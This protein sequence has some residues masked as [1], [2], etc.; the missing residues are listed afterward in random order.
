M[1]RVISQNRVLSRGDSVELGWR[2][3]GV[4]KIRRAVTTNSFVDPKVLSSRR[5]LNFL[6]FPVE[7]MY[8]RRTPRQQLRFWRFLPLGLC[9]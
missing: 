3:E 8:V 6:P 9:P 1:R 5:V 4:T 7:K 2:S